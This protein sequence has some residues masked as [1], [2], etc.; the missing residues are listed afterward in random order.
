MLDIN[1]NDPTDR[2]ILKE[3]QVPGYDKSFYGCERVNV[4]S[5]D[6]KTQIPVSL[7]YRKD[8]MEKHKETGQAIPLLLY[9]T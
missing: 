3:R 4:L 5:R 8:T 6:G 9:G 2:L 1:L 7:V